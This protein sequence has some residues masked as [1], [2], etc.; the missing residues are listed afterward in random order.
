MYQSIT[1]SWLAQEQTLA[2]DK[3]TFLKI[4]YEVMKSILILLLGYRK[5]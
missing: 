2:H 3:N 5:P 1:P 4:V